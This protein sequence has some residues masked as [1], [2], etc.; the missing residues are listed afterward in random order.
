MTFRFNEQFEKMIFENNLDTVIIL[1]HM[2]PDGD[3]AGS[4]MGLAH[5]I[6]RNYPEIQVLPYLADTLDKGPKSLVAKDRIFHPFDKPEAERYGIIVCDTATKARMIG[7]EFYEKAIATMVIDHHAG[8]EGYGAVNNTKISVACAENIYYMLDKQCLLEARQE[9]YPN[10]ADYIYLGILHDTGGFARAQVTTMQAATD[11]LSMGVDHKE[12]MKTRQTD[13]LED[14]EKRAWLLRNTNREFGGAVAY[15]IVDQKMLH[16]HNITYEDIHCISDIL[17]NC[18]DIYLGFTM[19]EEAPDIWRCSF[20]SDEK[21]IDVNELLKPFGGGGHKAAS[22]LRKKTDDVNSL[23]K[24]IL[25]S[26]S[27]QHSQI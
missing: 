5:Y 13:T 25:K 21:W 6:Y 15:V 8:N 16:E 17:R 23:C 11:L 7:L 2:N 24:D 20:R 26:I 27:L 18:E 9:E 10:A 22:G 3:A 4:V 1:A 14:L 19:Y 12:L